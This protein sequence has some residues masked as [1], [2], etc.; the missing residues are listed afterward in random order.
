MRQESAHASCERVA[1]ARRVVGPKLRAIRWP[2]AA[3]IAVTAAGVVV[4]GHAAPL[5]YD[6]AFNRL[7]YGRLGVIETL[8][9]YDYPNNHLPFTVLQSLMPDRLLAWDPWTIRAVGAATGIAMV[10]AL[11]GAAAARHTT[12]LLGLFV[13]GGSPILV[14][15]LFVSR[16]YTFSAVLLL[17]AAALPLV[18]WHGSSVLGVCLGGVAL[19]LGTW[20]LPTNAFFAPGWIITVLAIRGLRAAVAGAAVYVTAV[21]MMFAPIASQVQAQSKARYVTEQDRWWP[22]IGDILSAMS[23]VPVLLVLVGAIAAAAISRERGF[24]SLT[25]VRG[26]DGSAFLAVL[27][28][29]MTASWFVLVGMA[30]AVG[31]QLPFVRTAVPAMWLAVVSLVAA[32]PRGRLEY[33]A[34]LLLAPALVLGALMWSAAVRAGDWEQVARTSRNDVLFGTTPATIRDVP[35][36][37]ADRIVCS[38]WDTWVCQ[39]VTPNLERSGV[40]V[41]PIANLPYDPGLSCAIGSRRPNPPWQVSV[42]RRDELLGV[43]CH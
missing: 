41:V 1:G 31:L 9:T 35:L 30:H 21:T 6:E 25:T 40:T 2:H 29:A 3:L 26:I 27:T 18:R 12:P 33:V 5:T 4:L 39:L 43:L 10:A 11:L 17:I 20:P 15:Y 28:F 34:L 16:G 8:R 13:V 14:S 37:G 38:T 32:F 42:Y 22:W 19:A 36:I 24:P 23:L 7:H